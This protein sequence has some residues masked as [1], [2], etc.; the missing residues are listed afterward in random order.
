MKD[1]IFDTPEK[2]EGALAKLRQLKGDPG[3]L[4]VVEVLQANI[5]VVK[6]QILHG[7]DD[8]TL[9]LTNLLRDRLSCYE[10][11]RD[12]PDKLI[13]QLEGSS[14]EEPVIDP[15]YTVDQLKRARGEIV[16]P[17]T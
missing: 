4:L 14:S 7:V 9:D 16:K 10:S 3:W 8:E 11:L 2:R 15:F 12:T 5:D 1:T 13:A 17:T 6:D